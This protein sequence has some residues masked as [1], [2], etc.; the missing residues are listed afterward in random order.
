MLRQGL[1]L[2][3]PLAASSGSHRPRESP[4]QLVPN[5]GGLL[6]DVCLCLGHTGT[7]EA[8]ARHA[9]EPRSFQSQD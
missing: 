5:L 8:F 9:A 1:S 6:P 7:E 4:G 3:A 2:A